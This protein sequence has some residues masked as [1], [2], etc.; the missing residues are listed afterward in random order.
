ME[1]LLLADRARRVILA[2]EASGA[3]S[4]SRIAAIME[5]ITWANPPLMSSLF[6]GLRTRDAELEGGL[7][8][9]LS[10]ARPDSS[11]RRRSRAARSGVKSSERARQAQ[12]PAAL[13]GV[14]I[15]ASLPRPKTS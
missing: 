13:P 4:V 6:S 14:F 15:R 9:H 11:A 7:A 8:I 12:L 1:I 3:F 2:C 10:H 5:A